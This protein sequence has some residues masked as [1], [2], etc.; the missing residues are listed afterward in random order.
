MGKQNT[1]VESISGN[2]TDIMV[3]P[4]G[5][6]LKFIQTVIYVKNAFK[7]IVG[8]ISTANDANCG[9]ILSDTLPRIATLKSNSNGENEGGI[10][11]RASTK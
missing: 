1:R 4:V 9:I 11:P 6:A 10:A 7:T 5:T 3:E 2:I 8:S